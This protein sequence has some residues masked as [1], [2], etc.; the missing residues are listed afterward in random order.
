MTGGRAKVSSSR[1][2]NQNG[3]DIQ[4]LGSMLECCWHHCRPIRFHCLS[5]LSE[6]GNQSFNHFKYTVHAKSYTWVVFV[7]GT[8]TLVPCH[9]ISMRCGQRNASLF[10][11]WSDMCLLLVASLKV[12]FISAWL[13]SFEYSGENSK[14][15]IGL[16]F[17]FCKRE[18]GQDRGVP[19]G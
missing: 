4:N 8:W 6:L 9:I 15:N 12:I 14:K 7:H 19:P 17:L 1:R 11:S 3:Q 5:L 13:D 16:T 2:Q 18:L 10:I